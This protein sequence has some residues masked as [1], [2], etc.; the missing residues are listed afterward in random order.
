MAVSAAA[1][2]ASCAS[3]NSTIFSP[4]AREAMV[5]AP[6]TA[7]YNGAASYSP[8]AGYEGTFWSPQT[9]GSYS[10]WPASHGYGDDVGINQCS[11][12]GSLYTCDTNGDGLADV[13]G[14]TEDGSYASP[15]LRVNAKGKAFTW[16]NACACW[17][18]SP[19][20]DGPR[21]PDEIVISDIRDQD[22][23]PH[24]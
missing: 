1:F 10:G 8:T 17:Q 7:S 11:H 19:A 9:F 24:Q 21:Q 18:R 3:D 6:Y 14:D 12:S 22:S 5:N 13:Y 2:V 23:G 4:M 16:D 20:N 15:T